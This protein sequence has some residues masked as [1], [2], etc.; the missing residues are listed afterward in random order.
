MH[1]V[2]VAPIDELQ[3]APCEKEP[4]AELEESCYRTSISEKACRPSKNSAKTSA[5][6]DSALISSYVRYPESL[7][8]VGA[9]DP[10]LLTEETA[11]PYQFTSA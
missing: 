4:S 10:S 2:G 1:N 9:K 7:S 5:F 6:P 3:L 11:P 8:N